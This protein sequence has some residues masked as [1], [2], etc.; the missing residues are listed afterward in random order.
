MKKIFNRVTVIVLLL[1]IALLVAGF[2]VRVGRSSTS[3]TGGGFISRESRSSSRRSSK[4]NLVF[5]QWWLNEL[6]GQTLET[7][8]ADFEHSNPGITITLDTRSYIGLENNALAARSDAPFAG[9]IIALDPQWFYELIHNE[10]L[11]PLNL[12][13]TASEALP[14][15]EEQEYEAWAIPLVSFMTPFFY[16]IELLRQAGF[17]R[18]PKTRDDFMACAKALSGGDR[19]GIAFALSP[20]YPQGIPLDIYSWIWAGGIRMLNNGKPA[21]TSRPV[22]ETLS[23]LKQFHDEGI[24]AP[25]CFSK[26]RAQKLDDFASGTIGLMIASVQDIETLR[27]RMG[28]AGF[29]VTTIPTPDSYLQMPSMGLSYWYAGI[30]RHSEHKEA[31]WAFLSYL[32]ENAP[33][34]AIAAHAVPGSGTA[35][36]NYFKDDALYAKAY[37]IYESADVIEEFTGQPKTHTREIIVWE[38]VKNMLEADQSAAT[39]AHNIQARWE[40]AGL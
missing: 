25:D 14:D 28:D 37:D 10:Q 5:S 8:I 33:S 35:T 15:A 9:D 17:D 27:E 31:A 18:P 13:R 6:E 24:L 30:S 7:L 4:V 12:Y 39:T 3:D 40:A 21:I 20:D 32:A 29:G 16:N 19:F 2:A 26:T 22:I 38:E 36:R 23:F 11:E 1:G 34:L